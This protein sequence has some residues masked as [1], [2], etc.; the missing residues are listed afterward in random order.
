MWSS[1]AILKMLIS[2][3]NQLS[4]GCWKHSRYGWLFPGNLDRLIVLCNGEKL[5]CEKDAN[6]GERNGNLW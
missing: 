3:T 2:G 1:D 4:F 5:K 6:L